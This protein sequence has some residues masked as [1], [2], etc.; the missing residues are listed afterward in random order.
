MIALSGLALLG[1]LSQ[2][3]RQ[4]S[5]PRQREAFWPRAP[6]GGTDDVCTN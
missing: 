4:V 1:H 2:R 5:L 6:K 3:E